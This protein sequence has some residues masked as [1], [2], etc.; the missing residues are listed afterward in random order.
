MPEVMFIRPGQTV[1][2]SAPR[3]AVNRFY[4]DVNNRMEVK[5]LSISDNAVTAGAG[6]ASRCSLNT[7][8]TTN[9]CI[10]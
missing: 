5:V 2:L 10:S 1:R 8:C 9:A 3:V 6:A 7:F 4:H